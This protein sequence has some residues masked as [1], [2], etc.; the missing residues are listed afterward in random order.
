MELSC[1]N[2]AHLIKKQAAKKRHVH[3]GIRLCEAFPYAG[4]GLDDV[5]R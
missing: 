1:S 3:A 4:D 5:F 2:F